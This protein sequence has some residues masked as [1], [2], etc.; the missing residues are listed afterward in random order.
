MLRPHIFVYMIVKLQ[1]SL[2]GFW[3]INP[4]EKRQIIVAQLSWLKHA[5]LVIA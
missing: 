1:L 4:G 3:T 2:P 5:T